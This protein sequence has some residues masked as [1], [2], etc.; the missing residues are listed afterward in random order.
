MGAIVYGCSN[1]SSFVGTET[2]F[3]AKRNRAASSNSAS[4]SAALR[5]CSWVKAENGWGT[6]LAETTI[7]VVNTEHSCLG[8]RSNSHAIDMVGFLEGPYDLG[9]DV[10]AKTFLPQ[11]H[12]RIT[13][14]RRS[15]ELTT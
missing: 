2:W 1:R 15:S 4:L 3:C 6:G 11:I 13:L 7:R 10:F 14:S 12:R 9:L 5:R 8:K